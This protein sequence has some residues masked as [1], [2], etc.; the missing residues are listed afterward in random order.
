MLILF[1]TQTNSDNLGEGTGSIVGLL[2]TL[3][4]PMLLTCNHVIPNKETARNCSIWFDRESAE[5]PGIEVKGSEL[6]DLDGDGPF[7]FTTHKVCG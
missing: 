1:P 3:L 5:N 2:P 4:D 7:K 6:F